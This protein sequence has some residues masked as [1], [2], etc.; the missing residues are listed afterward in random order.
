M[1]SVRRLVLAAFCVLLIFF[2]AANLQAQRA[3]TPPVAPP[4]QPVANPYPNGLGSMPDPAGK[5]YA[6]I[7]VSVVDDSGALLDEQALVKVY[8]QETNTSAWGTTQ[9][10]GVAEFD[11]I[12]PGDYEVEISAAGFKTET[13]T[14]D[15]VTTSHTYFV[16]VR[17]KL[18]ENG[19]SLPT[20][21]GQ[22]LAPKAR[23]ETEKGLT[24][25]RMGNLN[26]AQKHL[27]AAFQLA[28][29]NAD[30]AFLLGYLFQ[31]K[32]DA[33]QAKEYF[34]KATSYNPQHL[35]ALTSLGQMLL[36]E[37]NY[38]EAIDPLEKA[39]QAD[40]DHWQAHSMLASAYLHEHELEKSR[41]QAE[42]AIQSGKGAAGNAQ[43]VL[44]DALAGL[45][46]PKEAID[47]YQIFLTANPSSPVAPAVRDLIAKLQAPPV[48][49]TTVQPAA[50][51]TAAAPATS[52]IAPAPPE[53]KLSLPSW[54]PPNIDDEKP[55]VS[56]G[57]KCPSD[58][59]IDQAGKRVKELVDSLS[60]FDATEYVTH[61]DLDELGKGVTKETRKFDYT[62][63]ISEP[64]KDVLRVEEY[65]TSMN[66]RGGFPGGLAT[67]GL[68]ALAF[69]FH[70]DMRDEFDL[71]CEG[72]G[73][74]HGQATWLVHFRQRSDKPSHL[75]SFDFTNASFTVDL[76]GRAWI[77]ASNY[78]IVRLEADLVSPLRNIQ[79]LTE[80]QTVEYQPIKFTKTNSV[81]WLP[82]SADIYMDF[83]HERFHRRHSFSHYQLF[84]VGTSQKISQPK[85]PDT[86]QESA[87][88]PE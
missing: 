81:V 22:V 43:L 84:S 15:V 71:V 76:K 12:V 17:L 68:P 74:W 50:A 61:E 82:A 87:K 56:L 37:G 51:I 2:I 57:T 88:K 48:A 4:G 13:Q 66:D 60:N 35:R 59:V 78:Q 34:Q 18:D 77:A 54:G 11:Q 8:G 38:K 27:M 3:G 6:S 32:K 72:L 10:R 19:A 86:T 75:Q 30:V 39:V 83:R 33:V 63:A 53:A 52:F 14:I 62:V 55:V 1:K 5:G 9:D 16:N 21:P 58:H 64:Q 49:E 25:L 65:R 24:A 41:Q 69:V 26:D 7:M 47:A 85:V 20:K 31:Q 70:P 79:L 36:D 23:K 67:H 80:H 45:G 40:P 28:P 29:T 73:N 42:L 46:K 44:G